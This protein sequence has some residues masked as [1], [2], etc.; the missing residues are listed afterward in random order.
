MAPRLYY[1]HIPKTAGTS[2]AAVLADRFHASDIAPFR[3]H[4]EL[5]TYSPVALRAYHCFIGHFGYGFRRYL[6]LP[7]DVITV[8][9]DPI[10][11]CISMFRDL[12]DHG[13][14]DPEVTLS[15]ALDTVDVQRLINVQ[16][17]WLACDCI[18][19]CNVGYDLYYSAR[20]LAVRQLSSRTLLVKAKDRLRG[21]RFV[22]ISERFRQS[23]RLLSEEF[24]WP[25]P[26]HTPHLNVRGLRH[27]EYVDPDGLRQLREMQE[28]DRELYAFGLE[29]F[30]ERLRKTE[31]GLSYGRRVASLPRAKEVHVD[32]AGPLDGTGWYERER[33]PDGSFARWTGPE[34]RA[35]IDLPLQQ[36]SDLIVTFLVVR[37]ITESIVESLHVRVNGLGVATERFFNAV[38][39]YERILYRCKVPT[40]VLQR[41]SEFTRLELEVKEAA[42]PCDLELTNPD[43]RRLG[44]MVNWLCVQRPLSITGEL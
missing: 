40:D 28:L 15:E 22:G 35:S 8:L 26:T 11:Q 21:M 6:G 31:V 32:F 37:G 29:L 25:M 38:G 42:R 9:R 17:R 34:R 14:L 41:N 7:C 23:L 24:G 20:E 43:D 36:D 12:K 3:S 1:L 44:V 13:Q 10:D 19:T 33:L 39:V 2:L 18:D 16:T 4:E 5:F 30:H 27:W